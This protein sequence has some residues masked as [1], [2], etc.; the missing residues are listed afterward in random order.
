M[1]DTLDPEKKDRKVYLSPLVHVFVAL[2]MQQMDLKY[3]ID[4]DLGFFWI[5]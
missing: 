4:L 5:L 3:I 1:L 2:E